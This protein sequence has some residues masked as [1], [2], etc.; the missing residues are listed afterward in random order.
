MYYVIDDQEQWPFALQDQ[1]YKLCN[2]SLCKQK[3]EWKPGQ[4]TR[5]YAC[6]EMRRYDYYLCQLVVFKGC[7]RKE[8]LT[9]I[10]EQKLVTSK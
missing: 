3:R 1:A 4:K 10:D 7:F 8:Q 6:Q 5:I 2:I 9:R